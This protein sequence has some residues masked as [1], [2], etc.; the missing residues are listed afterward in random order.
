MEKLLTPKELSDLLQVKV[1]TIYSWTHMEFI[2][3]IKVGRL[4]RFKEEEIDKWMKARECNGRT[5]RSL[6]V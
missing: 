4:L 6:V 5:E 2:P 1:S 3:H